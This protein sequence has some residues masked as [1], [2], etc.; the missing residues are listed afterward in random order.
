MHLHHSEGKTDAQSLSSG[1]QQTPVQC[2]TVARSTGWTMQSA[3]NADS[4]PQSALATTRSVPTSTIISQI[5]SILSKGYAIAVAAIPFRG[6][7]SNDDVFAGERESAPRE[8]ERQD[9]GS[10]QR[11]DI[12]CPT[13]WATP[14]G[15]I[16]Y[17]GG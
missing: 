6:K 8:G 11:E 9:K 10:F 1:A 2:Q 4:G 5:L 14:T 17:V 16:G 12:L 13:V 3:S 7:P 15:L